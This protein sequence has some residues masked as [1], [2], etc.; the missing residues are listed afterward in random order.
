MVE[1]TFELV[2]GEKKIILNEE[3]LSSFEGEAYFTEKKFIEYSP[4]NPSVMLS[5]NFDRK[6]GINQEQIGRAHV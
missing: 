2:E 1:A 6:Q 5:L 4:P 3:T